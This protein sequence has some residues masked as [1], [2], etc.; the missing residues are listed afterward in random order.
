MSATAALEA[1]R[2]GKRFGAHW[3]L[4]DCSLTVPSGRVVALVGPNG[5]GK[6]T[7]L[8]LAVGLTEPSAGRV[9]VLGGSPR[10]DAAQILPRIGFVAQDHPLYRGFTLAEL[11]RVGAKLNARWDGRIARERLARLD[12]T[13]ER[14]IGALSRGEQAQVAL[15]L[16]LAKQPRFLLLDEPVA[17]LDPVARRDFLQALLEAV[18]EN[19]LTVLL[20]SHILSDLERVCDHIVVLS[21]AR[22]QLAGDI[23]EVLASHR[24]L[25]GP[26]C[27]PAAAHV[28][29]IL[30]ESHSERQSNL[31]VRTNGNLFD[32]CWTVSEVGLEEIILAYLT[33][34]TPATKPAVQMEVA[35]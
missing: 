5:A 14:K 20:S 4:R 31:L 23:D 25:I 30:Q 21:R 12:L 32:A 1:E 6:T 33:R 29:S 3:A 18:A 34:S 26:R 19:E 24:R 10:H 15:S 22:L 17:S 9:V 35:S 8:H 13:L 11:L 28:G 27:D 2:L 7:L 16:A